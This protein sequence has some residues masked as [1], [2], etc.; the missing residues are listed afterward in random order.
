MT[1]IVCL[2][3][4]LALGVVAELTARS[5]RVPADVSVIGFDDSPLAAVAV[6]PLTTVRQPAREKGAAAARLLLDVL[7]GA[8]PAGPVEL[9]TA[10]VVRGST[11]KPPRRSRTSVRRSLG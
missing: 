9:A 6:P 11:A 10:L 1:A 3:D 8:Q 4:E 5:V 7:G 2:S